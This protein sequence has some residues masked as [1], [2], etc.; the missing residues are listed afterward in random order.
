MFM[1]LLSTR[2]PA[3]MDSLDIQIFIIYFI[4]LFPQLLCATHL[5]II[6]TGRRSLRHTS[7]SPSVERD[8]SWKFLHLFFYTLSVGIKIMYI[9]ILFK[10][11]VYNMYILQYQNATKNDLQSE[12]KATQIVTSQLMIMCSVIFFLYLYCAGSL[13]KKKYFPDSGL[14]SFLSGIMTKV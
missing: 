9:L 10:Y 2:F 4:L 1:L 8:N 11:C 13:L 3:A 7:S 12:F 14:S 6:I 5:A